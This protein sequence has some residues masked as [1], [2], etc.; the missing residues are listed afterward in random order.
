MDEQE[1]ISETA[2][3]PE[4]LGNPDRVLRSTVRMS[5]AAAPR[6]P[7]RA[8]LIFALVGVVIALAAGGLYALN[9]SAA[10]PTMTPE[11]TIREFLA[12]VFLANSADRVKMVVC[13]SW[14][15]A[16]ALSRT[17]REIDGDTRV[18]WDE[19]RVLSATDDRINARARLGLRRSGDIQPSSY[20]QWRFSLVNE[21]GWRVCE[22]RPFIV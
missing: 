3:T 17:A 11:E 10:P 8:P 18:S 9:R 1:E 6:R 13:A 7:T 21:D 14:D 5:G 19:V 2:E 4:R 22:A 12:A 16:D 20:R 15:P